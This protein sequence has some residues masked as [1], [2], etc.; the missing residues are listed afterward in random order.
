MSGI[1]GLCH[2]GQTVRRAELK[3]MLAGLSLP[4]EVQA[5]GPCGRSLGL[6]V[7]RRWSFQQIGSV[8]GVQVA[9]DAD[10]YNLRELRNSLVDHDVD[11]SALSLP[12]LLAW[13]FKTQGLDFIKHVHGVFSLAFWDEASQRLILATD[14]L[15]AKRLYWCREG[16]R[17]LFGS[18]PSAIRAGQ[19]QPAEVDPS[20]IIQYLLF[21]AVPAPLAIY[22]G[23]E[24]LSAGCFLIYEKGQLRQHRYWDLPYFESRNYDEFYWARELRGAMRAA[25]GRHLDGCSPDATGAYLSGGTDS[26]SVVAFMNEH[27]HPVNTFTIVFQDSRFDESGFARTTAEHFRTRHHERS[28][29]PGDAFAAIQKLT[30]YFDEPFGN[31]SAFGAYYCALLAR[32]AGMDTLL[33]GDGGDELFAGNQRYAKDRYFTLYSSVPVWLRRSI[34]EPAAKFLPD[35]GGWLGLP[36]RF[37]KRARI[38]NPRRLLSYRA[39]FNMK[40]EQVFDADFLAQAPTDTWLDIAEGHFRAAR[41]Q[42]ELNR[43]LYLDAKVTLADNDLHKVAG[44]AEL[45]GIRVRFPLLDHRLVELAGEI[46][47]ALKLRGF[48]KRYIFK[49]AMK[50]I[51]PRRVLFKKKHGFGVPLGQWLIHDS[52]WKSLAR[53]VLSDAA[54]RQRGYFRREF[55]DQLMNGHNRDHPSSY[56]T[57][58]WYLLTLELWHRQHL[59]VGQRGARAT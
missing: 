42:S 3:S 36:Q 5:E 7:A 58:L 34:I 59:E 50:G 26:S 56:G 29:N 48:E 12:E 41:S 28:L 38:P 4:D 23:V 18:R 20:A 39:L 40:P 32:E 43:L 17:L 11:P 54:T 6:G 30:Q 52:R 22:R 47:P 45:A 33:A 53:D 21:G 14:R 44:T 2:P 46:P 10:L 25:V 15:G 31:S 8:P 1:C 27:H 16:D 37:L 19:K 9:V 24:R 13:C 35:N 51:L 55:F 49:Q 57:V